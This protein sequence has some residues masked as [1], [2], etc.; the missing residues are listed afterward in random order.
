MMQ[1]ALAADAVDGEGRRSIRSQCGP[2]VFAAAVGQLRTPLAVKMRGFEDQFYRSHSSTVINRYAASFQE[3]PPTETRDALVEAMEKTV[4]QADFTAGT[5]AQVILAIYMVLSGKAVDDSQL[6]E[7]RDRLMPAVRKGA[8]I[9]F[10]IVHR[11]AADEELDQYIMLLRAHELQRF[12]SLYKSA[13][14]NVMIR[15]SQVL[16]AMIKQHVDARAARH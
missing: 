14:Q 15:S 7:I 6:S 11:N 3:K 8:R 12:Q 13:V 5:N 4:H 1:Q 16:A 9:E 2:E 10:L